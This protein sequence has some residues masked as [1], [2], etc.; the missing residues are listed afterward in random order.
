MEKVN[1]S[2]NSFHM[3]RNN[4]VAKKIASSLGGGGW[5][6]V[7]CPPAVSFGSRPQLTQPT[8]P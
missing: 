5:K 6:G 7:H 4:I 1:K 8:L 3:Y 2:F